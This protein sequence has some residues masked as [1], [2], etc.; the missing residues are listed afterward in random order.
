[1]EACI[2]SSE[3]KKTFLRPYQRL[4]IELIRDEIRKGHKRIGLHMATGSGKGLVMSEITN[5]ALNNGKK[6]ITIMR[7]RELIHQTL[8][9]Y[10]KYHGIDAA[11]IMA[12]LKFNFENSC[13]VCSI[14]T[15]RSR[16]DKL[17]FLT[18]FDIVIVDEFHDT[19]STSYEEFFDFMGEDKI[20]LGFSATPFG[21]KKF[22][23]AV[24]KPIEPMQL[25]DQNFLCQA[26]T[27][28]P[29][30]IDVKGINIRNGEFAENELFERVKNLKI[31]GD[32]VDTYKKYGEDRPAILFAVNI[33]HSM[34]MAE[35]FRQSGIPATHQDQS[36]NSA[37]RAS[38]IE[39]LR[40]GKIK[41]LCNVNI[42]STGVDIPEA[43]V[44]IMARPTR[45]E[46]LWIQQLGRM[47][48]PSKDKPYAI[49]LDHAGNS[50]R[51]GFAFDVRSFHYEKEKKEKAIKVQTCQE[52]YM[53]ME[54]EID[55]CEN[56]GFDLLKAKQDAA[57]RAGPTEVA[58]E[59]I[60]I[61]G[62]DSDLKDEFRELTKKSKERNWKK[63]AIW[64]HLYPRWGD[65]IYEVL[66]VPQYA[67]EILRKK[68]PQGR[69]Y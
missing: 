9:N 25:R 8:K 17:W 13:Q 2:S 1:M 45:S 42:F 60:E 20:Y 37:E 28:A 51:H 33:E 24:S 23:Q 16:M 18:N 26:R 3:Q 46:T 69:H 58:G 48:R 22:W 36:H 57:A 64:F 38:A 54:P 44:G 35:A 61:E 67:R 59:L 6:V 52:C 27:F 4:A 32:I 43:S 55:V 19:K 53:V 49:I 5:S 21:I 68:F 40:S 62:Q 7:R 29:C 47:L 12:G 63:M 34:I 66:P 31:V 10:K 50:E 14:D 56:C 11:P 65:E 39:D 15:V 41:V 30:K